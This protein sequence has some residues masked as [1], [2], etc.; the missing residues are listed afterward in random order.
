MSRREDYFS[1]YDKIARLNSRP[2]ID[3]ADS[4]KGLSPWEWIK[5]G[6]LDRGSFNIIVCCILVIITMDIGMII[7]SRYPIPNP[8]LPSPYAT[9]ASCP[10]CHFTAGARA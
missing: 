5:T 2:I 10:V 7:I 8:Q 1:H 9:D 4:K 6:E 3:D